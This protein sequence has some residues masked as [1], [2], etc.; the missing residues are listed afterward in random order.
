MRKMSLVSDM[1]YLGKNSKFLQAKPM[2]SH[3]P[4]GCVFTELQV[5]RRL[6]GVG[7]NVTNFCDA[8]RSSFVDEWKSV[9]KNK[10]YEKD[11]NQ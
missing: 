11:V 1:S 3:T 10:K 4:V 7:S 9:G 5:Y 8:V 6:L 2:T